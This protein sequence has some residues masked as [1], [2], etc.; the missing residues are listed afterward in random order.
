[1]S[2]V[3]K[4]I[5]ALLC[6]LEIDFGSLMKLIEAACLEAHLDDAEIEALL[7]DPNRDTLEVITDSAD[8]LRAKAQALIAESI[9]EIHAFRKT[10]NEAVE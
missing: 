5:G 4:D 8:A 10:S 2:V 9:L 1:M 6:R 3:E 7:R